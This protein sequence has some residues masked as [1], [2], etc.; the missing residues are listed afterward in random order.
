MKSQYWAPYE[1]LIKQ[2]FDHLQNFVQL[3]FI[4]DNDDVCTGVTCHIF[5]LEELIIMMMM[6]MMILMMMVMKMSSFVDC[7]YR[8][9]TICSVN[10]CG[11]PA[12][13]HSSYVSYEPKDQQDIKS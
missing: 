7:Q 11:D 10:A 1:N 8:F 4:S 6:V 9:W 13:N 2:D 5:H 12:R 3:L